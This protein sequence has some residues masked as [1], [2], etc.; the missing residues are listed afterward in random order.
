[1]LPVE[2]RFAIHELIALHGHV[3]DD[4]RHDQLDLLFTDD[5]V[6]D[7]SAYGAGVVRGL[8]AL[9]ELFRQRPGAQPI[10]HHVTNVLVGEGDDRAVAVR[11]KGLAVM[12][13]GTAGTVTYDDVVVRTEAG[14]RIS[15][16]A[17]I[18]ARV[19]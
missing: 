13:D 6:Y 3:V 19:E 14:W 15:R 11:S 2:D 9:T 5:A 7:V 17:V 18:P 16:R 1:M 12:A 10:G 8:D 4:R